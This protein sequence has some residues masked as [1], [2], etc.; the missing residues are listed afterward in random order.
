MK[1]NGSRTSTSDFGLLQLY[2]QAF[3]RRG[4]TGLTAAVLGGCAYMQPYVPL[5][6]TVA[7]SI[8]ATMPRLED[9]IT[10]VDQW[11]K[12]T[13]RLRNSVS[14]TQRALNLATFGF[15]FGFGAGA[16]SIYD[17]HRDAVIGLGLAAS[18]SYTGGAL[19][20]PADQATL[21][22]AAIKSLVCIR[23]KADTLR[24]T[25]VSGDDRRKS[26]LAA[27][28]V[29]SQLQP[30]RCQPQGALKSAADAA[31][32]ARVRAVN[33]LDSARTT[34]PS[35]A[36]LATTAGLN[37][38]TALND[39][40]SKRAASAEA[41]LAAAKS[42]VGMAVSLAGT[43]AGAEGTGASKA[44]PA[45]KPAPVTQC[46]G[47]AIDNITKLETGYKALEG[48]ITSALNALASLETACIFN[49]PA[50]AAMTLSQ[51]NIN[52]AKDSSY[53]ITIAGGRP[54]YRADWT[55]TVPTTVTY[56]L[57]GASLVIIA[58]AN[59]IAGEEY[60]LHVSDSAAVSAR[61]PIKLKIK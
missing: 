49:A 9:A 27:G 48:S 10:R 5:Y 57:T 35:A 32:Q 3:S 31:E 22:N 15:G 34:D 46:T 43:P 38:V 61:K 18:A 28:Y 44:K 25:V 26:D 53:V 12:D 17:A 52:L 59:A 39:E 23:I 2:L 11:N 20:A 24:A 51:D 47:P 58:S 13:E 6:P 21:Y 56:Q 1:N 40:L 33:M 16:A 54:V 36:N 45:A 60:E 14:L 42:A 41:V 29:A 50:V 19:F 4:L 37:V 7:T 55:G 30:P 8:S